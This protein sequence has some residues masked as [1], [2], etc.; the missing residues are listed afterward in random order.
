M[1]RPNKAACTGLHADGRGNFA[2]RH[3]QRAEQHGRHESRSQHAA[4]AS[5][6]RRSERIERQHPE[7]ALLEHG[8]QQAKRDHQ[9]HVQR[10]GVQSG[11]LRLHD[12]RCES[13]S[14]THGQ[15]VQGPRE[16]TAPTAKARR[17]QSPRPRRRHSRKRDRSQRRAL[18][19]RPGEGVAGNQREAARRSHQRRH[20]H[21][22]AMVARATAVLK[23]HRGIRARH[24]ASSPF[25]IEYIVCR[26]YTG[27]P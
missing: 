18:R 15:H 21:G 2:Q 17:A 1:N 7:D 10:G 19:E 22:G 8:G 25:A 27:T 13:R 6:Q 3:V 24:A 5:S 12:Q 4:S 16:Q 14:Q 23:P 11:S 26:P 20:E 9:H